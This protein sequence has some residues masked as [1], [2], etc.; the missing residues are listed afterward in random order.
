MI[1]S[2]IDGTCYTVQTLAR[3]KSFSLFFC[4]LPT[5]AEDTTDDPGHGAGF[6]VGLGLCLCLAVRTHHLDG[7]RAE[8]GRL[9]DDH[10]RCRLLH[11]RLTGRLV[12]RRRRIGLHASA[13][14]PILGEGRVEA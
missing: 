7:V 5:H 6:G 3:S 1:E 4:L 8:R 10:R 9:L 12:L 2:E 14:T 13:G 11:H